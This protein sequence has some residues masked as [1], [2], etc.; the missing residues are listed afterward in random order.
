[1]PGIRDFISD[2][3]AFN[4]VELSAEDKQTLLHLV[5]Q[6]LN[7]Y[8][9]SGEMPPEFKT[10]SPALLQPRATFVTLRVRETGELRGC[11]GEVI[12]RQP[13]VESVMNMVIASATDDPR[14]PPVTADEVPNLHLEIS[15]LT[16]MKPIKPEEVVVGRHGLMIV[17][18]YSSGLL[19]PQVPVEQGSCAGC[20]TKPGFR[21]TPGRTR[22]HNYMALKQRCGERKNKSAITVSATWPVVSARFAA[23]G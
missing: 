20:V 17:K 11:R 10:D 15:A 6:T 13:L 4:A 8:L 7:E 2:D 21:P 9:S 12:A 22:T 19:L 14:F 23:T 3:V 16:P 5:R 1:M 18:G